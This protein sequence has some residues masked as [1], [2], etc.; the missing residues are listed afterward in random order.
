MPLDFHVS[1]QRRTAPCCVQRRS[2]P[3]D[4]SE[5]EE[6]EEDVNKEKECP[7]GYHRSYI[8]LCL[9]VFLVILSTA[10]SDVLLCRF[11]NLMLSY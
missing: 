4:W 8:D 1:F 6:E 11:F 2:A 3:C 7:E 5:K 9:L 10:N